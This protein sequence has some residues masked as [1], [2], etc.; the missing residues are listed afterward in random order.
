MKKWMIVVSLFLL[1]V[2]SACSESGD[3]GSAEAS[4]EEPIE[5]KFGTKMPE[6][7]LEGQMF[8]KFAEL[9]DE[10]SNGELDV[11][12]YPAE[13]LGKGTSQIDNMIMGTQQMYA[14]GITYFS[15]YDSR[16]DVASV[17]FLFRDFEHYQKFNTGEMGQDIHNKLAENGIRVLNTE[18]NFVRGPYRVMLSTEPVKDVSDLEGLDM[19]SFESEYYSA[20]YDHVG[21]NPTVIAWTETYLALKQN[22][23]NAV[24]S[25]ISLVW[26]MKF[27][28]VAPHMTIT[29]EYPQ[30]IVLTMSEEFYQGLSEEHQ[31]ILVEAANETGEENN[32]LI[33]AEVEEQLQKMKDE[34]DI[35]IHEID[36][37]EWSEAFSE[38]HYQ[39]E[40]DSVV[41]EGYIDQI[42]SIE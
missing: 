18:R 38:F 5:I 27:T 32:K 37:Q 19:R 14:D 33:E 26:S 9:V 40:E 3:A 6:E 28:E 20:A 34:H 2:V 8:N 21:A 4:A 41:P 22:L 15:D 17:P 39:L 35:T 36:K 12:V 24:T 42:K 11:K 16:V 7:S 10:K 13:Q 25:P 29:E 23:V 30:D 31:Q 1:M